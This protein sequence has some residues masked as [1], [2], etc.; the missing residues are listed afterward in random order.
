ML[1]YLAG[2]TSTS[3]EGTGRLHWRTAGYRARRSPLLTSFTLGLTLEPY[4]L[5]WGLV[6]TTLDFTKI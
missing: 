5:L 1:E 6:I 3:L 2:C 4:P